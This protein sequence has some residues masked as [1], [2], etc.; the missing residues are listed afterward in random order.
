MATD[1][2]LGAYRLTFDK[3]KHEWVIK[4]DGSERATRRVRT[5]EEALKVM[6]QLSDNQGVGTHVHKKDGKFQKKR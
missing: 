6:E 4:R 1:K 3:E 2:K 5:K